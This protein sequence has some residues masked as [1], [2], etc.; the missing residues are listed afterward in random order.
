MFAQEGDNMEFLVLAY[1]GA[2][3]AVPGRRL[4]NRA[5]HLELIGKLV[6]QGKVLYGAAILDE[7]ER[8]IGTAL[9]CD[10]PSRAEVDAWLEVEPYVTGGVWK[11]IDIQRCKTGPAFVKK[12]S[13]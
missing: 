12:P 9:V 4:A 2:D 7:A 5:A 3:G 8:M 1:D 11:K 10:F 13:K 6:A